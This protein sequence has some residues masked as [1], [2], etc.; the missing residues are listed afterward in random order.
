MGSWGG[1]DSHCHGRTQTGGVWDKWGRQS[2]HEDTLWPHIHAQ[3][4]REG[5]TQSGQERVRQCGGEHPA[6]PHSYIDKPGGTAGRSKADHA[7]Q[8]SSSG[9]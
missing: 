3:I 7:T 8:G 4:N 5:W 2:D 9:K 6:A 1:E